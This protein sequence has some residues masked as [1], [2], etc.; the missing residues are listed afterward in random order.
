[1]VGRGGV[2]NAMY[3][4]FTEGRTGEACGI[5][6]DKKA[7]NHSSCKQLV[8]SA[9]NYGSLFKAH[10]ADS[11]A[12]KTLIKA[13]TSGVGLLSATTSHSLFRVLE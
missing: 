6:S 9:K 13:V 3:A 2:V 5:E 1:M 7:M 8:L 4:A 11:D 12:A 10:E